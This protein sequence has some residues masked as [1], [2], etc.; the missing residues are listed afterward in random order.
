MVKQWQNLRVEEQEKIRE[1]LEN[2]P[3]AT[4]RSISELL[5]IMLGLQV[6]FTTIRHW[7]I[8]LEIIS[9]VC[10]LCQ[11]PLKHLNRRWCSEK[12]KKKDLT[13]KCFYCGKDKVLHSLQQKITHK[14]Y[15][16]NLGCYNAYRNPLNRKENAHIIKFIDSKIYLPRTKIIQ[17]VYRKFNI[18]IGDHAMHNYL[19]KKRGYIGKRTK[20]T[21]PEIRICK[22]C[23]NEF[24]FY[25]PK[26]RSKHGHQGQYCSSKCYNDWRKMHPKYTCWNCGRRKSSGRGNKTGLCINCLTKLG[27]KKMGKDGARYDYELLEKIKRKQKHL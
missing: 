8:N 9:Y 14:K 7:Q 10:K 22:N 5:N 11:K 13:V 3:Q 15:F 26:S 23:G 4:L 2:N 19:I 21:P 17:L 20:K 1:I 18:I 6:T 24:P 27:I 12:C 16:C 25:N